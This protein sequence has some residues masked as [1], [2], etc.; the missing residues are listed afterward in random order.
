M[1]KATVSNA[2][3]QPSMPRIVTN[4]YLVKPVA[5]SFRISRTLRKKLNAIYGKED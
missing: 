4:R 2:R 5:K 3:K 1:N